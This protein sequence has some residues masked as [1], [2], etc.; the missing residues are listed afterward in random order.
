MSDILLVFCTFPSAES[1]RQIGANLVQ[2]QLAAC[3]TLCPGAESIYRWQGQIENCTE[4][5][6]IIKTTRHMFSKLEAELAKAH[7]Y[8]VPEI[9]AVQADCLSDAYRSWIIKSVGTDTEDA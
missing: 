3:A 8:D 7:P 1:A 5:L 2:S 9:L 4:V 6:A